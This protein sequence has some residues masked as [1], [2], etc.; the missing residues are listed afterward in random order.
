M[1]V[2]WIALITACLV[3]T[4][5]AAPKAQT[6]GDG[7]VAAPAGITWLVFADDLHM[8]FR[9]TGRIR[10]FLLSISARLRRD[11]DVTVMRTSGP[12]SIE[13]NA[14]SDRAAVDAAIRKLSG[15]GLHPREVSE[16]IKDAIG[17][18]DIRLAATFSA[19]A[20]LLES[21]PATQDRRRVMLYISN[22][23]ETQRGRA[24]ASLFARAAQQAHVVVF[25]VNASALG[26]PID[27]RRVATDL[28]TQIVT[29]RHQTLRAIA[30]STGGSAF[31]DS[32][33]V[34]GTVSRIRTAVPAIK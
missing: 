34:A 17:E 27:D 1:K 11:G 19:A 9:N 8:D 33:D 3:S 21:A 7:S 5:G 16:L 6:A 13:L 14:T 22:G 2:V 20:T 28:W 26:P 15:A 32:V 23:Y 29:S 18:I 31:L 10:E 24:L 30:E 25:T 4:L 12:S